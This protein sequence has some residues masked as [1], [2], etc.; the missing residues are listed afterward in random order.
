MEKDLIISSEVVNEKSV[1]LPKIEWDDYSSA[2]YCASKC[3]S[4]DKCAGNRERCVKKAVENLLKTL[5]QREELVLKLRWGFY[6]NK[7]F[8]LN[9][10]AEYLGVTRECVRQIEAKALRKLGHPS[11]RKLL[12]IAGINI[13]NLSLANDLTGENHS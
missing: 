11:R 12:S 3:T 1:Q 8:T 5:T 9:D 7:C 10:I 6:G 13:E 2:D 4:F